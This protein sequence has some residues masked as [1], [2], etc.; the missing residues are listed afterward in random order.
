MVHTR[1]KLT[2]ITG[3]TA[4]GKSAFIYKHLSSLPL[5]VINADSRQ[6][7]RDVTIASASPN[8]A[9]LNLMPHALYNFLP[10]TEG[11]SAGEFM[12]AAKAEIAAARGRGLI[13]LICGGTYFYLQALLYGLLPTI[14]IPQEIFQRV[15]ALSAAEAYEELKKLDS[16]AAAQNHPHNVRR[17]KR[18]LSL[19]LAGNQPISKLVKTGGIADDFEI[20]MLIFDM[21]RARLRERTALRVRQMFTSGLVTE[22]EKLV[23]GAIGA[24][25]I[26]NWKNFPAYTGIGIREFFE[27]YE[28]DGITPARL[29]A[30][31]LRQIETAITQNTI[32]L[33]KRQ[34]TWYRNAEPKPA[35]TKTVDPS[36]ENGR[37][38]ALVHDF[39]K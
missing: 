5:V 22:V 35:N 7:Y 27:M 10:V 13:P 26:R 31:K 4:A 25:D 2:I 20:L 36:Y 34:Q 30:E 39:V 11:F 24:G 18:A 37:I 33:V 14:D 16:V 8:A 28:T 6:I 15:D 3:A 23:A 21:D 12:R 29:S 9:E 1:P 38:A 19:C 17:V 32:H